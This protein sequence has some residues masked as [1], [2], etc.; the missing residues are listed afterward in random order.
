MP[1]FLH[2]LVRSCRQCLLTLSATRL[3]QLLSKK[4]QQAPTLLAAA[5][6][7]PLLRSSNR[8]R[9]DRITFRTAVVSLLLSVVVSRRV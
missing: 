5:T 4:G 1:W 8:V 6:H 2:T 9:K 7:R 3:I